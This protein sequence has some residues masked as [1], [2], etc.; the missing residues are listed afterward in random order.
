MVVTIFS[1]KKGYFSPKIV[2][3]KK[4]SAI[5]RLKKQFRWPLSKRGGGKALMAW[6]LVEDFCFVF[7]ASLR[8]KHIRLTDI[9]VNRLSANRK[10]E[11]Y[12][13][14]VIYSYLK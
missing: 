5:L 6:P 2:G 4:V 1:K 11:I 13:Q 12:R 9:L 10:T 3:R 14:T 7:A 8:D